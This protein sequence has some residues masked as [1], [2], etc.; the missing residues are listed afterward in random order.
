[1]IVNSTVNSVLQLVLIEIEIPRSYYEKAVARHRSLG[2]WF[3]GPNRR[4]SDSGRLLFRKDLFGMGP[5]S[6][7]LYRRRNTISTT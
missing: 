3:A 4:W 2:E 1:M 5:W 6:G 7:R